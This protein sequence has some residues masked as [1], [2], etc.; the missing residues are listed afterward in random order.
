MLF[1]IDNNPNNLCDITNNSYK[2]ELSIQMK[3]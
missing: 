1:Q 2:A 3:Q